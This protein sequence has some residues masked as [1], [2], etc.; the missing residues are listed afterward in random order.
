MTP[1]WT[2]GGGNSLATPNT[3]TSPSIPHTPMSAPHQQYSSPTIMTSAAAGSVAS[4]RSPPRPY[5][6]DSN[7]SNGYQPSQHSN[8]YF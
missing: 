1:Q 4:P 6:N 5:R 2:P 7:H 3:Y 8:S